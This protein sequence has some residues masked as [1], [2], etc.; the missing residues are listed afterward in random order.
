MKMRTKTIV[1][2][3]LAAFATTIAV[4]GAAQAA[5]TFQFDTGAIAG[6]T[7][8]FSFLTNEMT[9]TAIGTPSITLTDSNNDGVIGGAD[10][11]AEIGITSIV[12][13]QL[14]N[15]NIPVGTTGVNNL[16]E[17]IVHFNFLGT[18]GIVGSNAVATFTSGSATIFY[19]EVVNSSSAGGVAI[20]QLTIPSANGSQCVLTGPGLAEGS[21]GLVLKFD[22]LGI[23]DPDVWTVDGTDLGDLDAV[24]ELDVDVDN[25]TPPFSLLYAGYGTTCGR[26]AVTGAILPL[27]VQNVT[28]DQDGSAVLNVPEPGTV[29]LLGIS[30]LGLAGSRRRKAGSVVAV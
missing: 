10:D 5:T 4:Q 12:N 15:A 26:D 21:C 8:N 22:A 18:A 20:A 25:V 9:F 30:L 14:N 27:C 3:L 28:T 1:K 23:T 7:T 24:A 2:Q 16:Y 13:F 11:F 17:L 19:D 29:A 6:S